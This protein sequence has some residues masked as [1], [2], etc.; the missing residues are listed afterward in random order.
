[1]NVALSVSPSDFKLTGFH[2]TYNPLPSQG[3]KITL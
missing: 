2:S 3:E 1:M